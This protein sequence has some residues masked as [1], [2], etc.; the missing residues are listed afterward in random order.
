MATLTQQQHTLSHAFF[1]LYS[2]YFSLKFNERNVLTL[3]RI[4]FLFTYLVLN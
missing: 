3:P 1:I 2:K 4:S